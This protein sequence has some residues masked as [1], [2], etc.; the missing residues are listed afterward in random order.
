MTREP[1]LAAYAWPTNAELIA[2]VA[3]LR[4]LQYYFDILDPTFGRGIWWRRWRPTAPGS[5]TTHAKP[6]EP[7][8]DFR[9][10]PYWPNTFDAVVLDPPY[11]LNGTDKDGTGERYGVDAKASIEER[12]DLIRDGITEAARVLKPAPRKQPGGILLLKCQDQVCSG[13]MQWQTR[14]FTDHADSIGLTLIDEFLH[15]G[16]GRPQPERFIRYCVGC[17]HRLPGDQPCKTCP[18]GTE[19]YKEMVRQQHAYG[20]PSSLLVF[21]RERRRTAHST[22]PDMWTADRYRPRPVLTVKGDTFK[23]AFQ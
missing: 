14:I 2:D 1:V 12:H 10:L 22:Q 17:D 19:E 8:F 9:D 7:E 23:E 4:Y 6:T 15:L 11:K 5:L 13:Q 20:R 16:T 18:A 21:K 3:R